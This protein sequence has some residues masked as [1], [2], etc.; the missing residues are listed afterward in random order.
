MIGR[1]LK[2]VWQISPP[3]LIRIAAALTLLA[4][5]LMVWSMLDPKP[6]PVMLAMSLGQLLGTI[7]FAMYGLA[8][9]K[10]LR[11]IQ[12]ERRESSQHIPV[13]LPEPEPEVKT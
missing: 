5:A 12:R 4:L 2:R 3:A 13:Q 8:I 11:R 10:D 9:Y 7:A 6:L 1:V